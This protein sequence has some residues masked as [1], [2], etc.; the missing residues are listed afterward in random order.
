MREGP[1]GFHKTKSCQDVDSPPSHCYNS[2][3]PLCFPAMPSF[4]FPSAGRDQ[5]EA[6]L[7][8]SDR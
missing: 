2:L 5:K 4:F 1:G 7:L 3:F 6:S 8:I